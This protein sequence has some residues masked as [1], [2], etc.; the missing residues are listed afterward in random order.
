M[1]ELTFDGGRVV[2]RH[3]ALTYSRTTLHRALGVFAVIGLLTGLAGIIIEYR[4][5]WLMLAGQRATAQV[6]ARQEHIVAW[7]V[8]R[9]GNGYPIT[10]TEFRFSF[11]DTADVER[12]G[13]F[14]VPGRSEKF[15]IGDPVGI[16]Y[17]QAGRGPGQPSAWSFYWEHDPAWFTFTL[18]G[19]CGFVVAAGCWWWRS[20][21]GWQQAQASTLATG[22]LVDP[23]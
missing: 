8:T 19:A 17:A 13:T 3:L 22:S 2:S 14:W 7:V 9:S 11:V 23:L 6:T 1:E 10:E 20:R 18:V 5:W 4:F 21:V 16:M 12:H 15:R